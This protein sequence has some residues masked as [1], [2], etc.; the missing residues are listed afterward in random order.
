MF[1][2]VLLE[3][4]WRGY[5]LLKYSMDFPAYALTLLGQSVQ[6]GKAATVVV[7]NGG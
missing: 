6:T 5:R 3:G 4:W 1:G 2:S 7:I